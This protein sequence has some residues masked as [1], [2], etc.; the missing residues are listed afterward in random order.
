VVLKRGNAPGDELHSNHGPH[1]AGLSEV[2]NPWA[3]CLQGLLG[4]GLAGPGGELGGRHSGDEEELG[5]FEDVDEEPAALKVFNFLHP[6]QVN[7][8]ALCSSGGD[9]EDAARALVHPRGPKG[10][11]VAEVRH[12]R[13]DADPRLAGIGED[14]QQGDGS[15][16]KV[17]R[18][19][20][21][22]L[23]DR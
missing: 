17:N 5:F 11:E 16:V 6:L 7:E 21:V 22:G 14:R 20:P 23:Q 13:L 10:E 18:L 15:G 1:D 2:T 9:E 3:E 8:V 4:K 12:R 19:D